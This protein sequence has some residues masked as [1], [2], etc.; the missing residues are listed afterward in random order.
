MNKPQSLFR[1]FACLLI[2][3]FIAV[4][5]F[6]QQSAQAHAYSAAYSTIT[7]TKTQTELVYALD[8]LSVIELIGGDTNKNYM[9]EQE[10]FDAIKDHM[11]NLI[12]DHVKLSINN[13]EIPWTQVESF[14]L[15]RKGDATKVIF[16]ALY[17]SVSA[18]DTIAL[19]DDLYV[20]DK[21]TNYVNLLTINYGDMKS[22]AALSGTDRSWLMLV[23]GDE[24][25]GFKPDLQAHQESQT[26]TG[27]GVVSSSTSGWFSF[28]KL[29]MNH[30]LSGY[31]HLLFLF[32]LLIARQ[33]FKQYATMITAFTIAHSATLTMTVLGW[34]NV[35]PIIVEPMI[36][37]SICYVAADNIFS[38][39]VKKRWMVTFAFGLIHG[40]GF[41][42]I[43]KEM[44][45][46]RSE[47]GINLISFNLGIEAVQITIVAL[48]L[49]L[50]YMMHRWKFSR[51]AVVFGSSV[52]LLLGGIWLF[53]RLIA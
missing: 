44:D 30:I 34:I 14:I 5:P 27:V 16:K 35:S 22:T 41:A 6:K 9:L 12:R 3:I 53:E 50:L 28:F 26:G 37:L 4:A 48:L 18:S 51:R 7:M 25:E 24:Y 40:M 31:D 1:V 17:P 32:S 33:T 38:K 15:D 23:T 21:K 47:L 52:A 43:L 2:V 39:N 46:P 8:E 13:K 11:V 19:S 45:I 42:D 36:A 29:G 20:N 49:P 10:E